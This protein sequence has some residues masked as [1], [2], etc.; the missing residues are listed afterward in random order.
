MTIPSSGITLHGICDQP[1]DVKSG[2]ASAVLL[3][4]SNGLLQDIKK[5]AKGDDGLQFVTGSAPVRPLPIRFVTWADA[6]CAYRNS[7]LAVA[8]LT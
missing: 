2:S 7:A 8:R 6:E 4:L 5:A 3:K 1:E